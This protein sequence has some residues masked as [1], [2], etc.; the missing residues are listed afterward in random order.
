M[1]FRLYD[2]LLVI[3]VSKAEKQL[4]YDICHSGKWDFDN[5]YFLVGWN[6]LNQSNGKVQIK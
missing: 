4:F 3:E 2:L 1:P 6:D 5:L